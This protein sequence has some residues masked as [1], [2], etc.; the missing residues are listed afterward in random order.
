M[1]ATRIYMIFIGFLVKIPLYRRFHTFLRQFHTFFHTFF[2]KKF[3]PICLLIYTNIL[4]KNQ[5]KKM[6]NSRDSKSRK[7]PNFHTY[8]A[9]F[10]QIRFF[11]KNRTQSLFRIH[12]DLTSCQKSEKINEPI[13]WK[14]SGRTDART[15]AQG[16]IYR[17]LPP[18]E[19][20]PKRYIASSP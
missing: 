12:R 9:I 18:K 11:L 14:S 17:T 2:E 7:K 4:Q 1:S 19:V 6:N 8:F 20:G 3:R 16:S 10:G 15:H 13:F 5:T